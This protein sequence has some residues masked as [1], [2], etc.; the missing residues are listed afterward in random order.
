MQVINARA[1]NLVDDAALLVNV[2]LPAGVDQMKPSQRRRYPSPRSLIVAI[3][4]VYRCLLRASGTRVDA[5]VTGDKFGFLV[6]M[7]S[8]ILRDEPSGPGISDAAVREALVIVLV[9]RRL[10]GVGVYVRLFLSE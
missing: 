5:D 10:L 1:A 7:G 9:I 8:F 3:D 6:R 2:P 4:H